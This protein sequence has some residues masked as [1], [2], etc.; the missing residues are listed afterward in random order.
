[1]TNACPS[2]SDDDQPITN[3]SSQVVKLPTIGRR[4]VSCQ[5]PM[6]PSSLTIQPRK[7]AVSVNPYRLPLDSA[8]QA[9]GSR[10]TGPPPSPDIDEEQE[11][12]SGGKFWRSGSP[13][14]IYHH[15]DCEGCPFPI[16]RPIKTPDLHRVS[17]GS[18]SFY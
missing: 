14:G 12:H 15:S 18:P 17:H 9:R 2:S 8:R 13:I 6:V 3:W 1:M 16:S 10:S 11:E 4:R 5:E 7:Q